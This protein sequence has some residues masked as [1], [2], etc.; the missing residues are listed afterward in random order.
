VMPA[1]GMFFR[2]VIASRRQ[3]AQQSPA[4]LAFC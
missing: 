3:A 4:V 2:G 1:S